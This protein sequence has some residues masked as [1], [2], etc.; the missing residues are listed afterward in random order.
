MDLRF[1]HKTRSSTFAELLADR[2]HPGP[3]ILY[4]GHNAY[5]DVFCLET[6]FPK[7]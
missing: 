5:V 4:A 6:C 3:K 7:W 2:G 1:I